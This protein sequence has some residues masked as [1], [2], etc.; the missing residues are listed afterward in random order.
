MMLYIRNTNR[1][2][3]K[4][5]EITDEVFKKNTH[6][7]EINSKSGLYALYCAYSVYRTRAKFELGP[8]PTRE[9]E[10]DLWK[11]VLAE[12]IF[13]ICKTPMA[14]GSPSPF[15]STSSVR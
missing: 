15:L 14:S 4:Q 3:I 1:N 11:K 13:L 12:N 7:L 5:N 8:K 9:M 6:I 10:I 2:L